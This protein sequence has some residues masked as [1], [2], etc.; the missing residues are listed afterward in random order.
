MSLV[1]K[2]GPSEQLFVNGAVLTNGERRSS[3]LVENA[4]Q[5]L[6]EKDILRE[7]EAS[8][9]VRAAYFAAQNVLLGT[10]AELGSITPFTEQIDCLRGAFIKPEH[11]ALLDEAERL[12]RAG[13]IYR[14]LVMLRDLVL[15]E[16]A[17][18]NM[19]PPDRFRRE[20]PSGST[21]KNPV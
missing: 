11:L 8:T 12:V 3:L 4:A 20:T 10:R 18:L 15:Y 1:L 19:Q 6:R 14:A 17:L 7:A 5:I 13:N 2:L 9:P 16:A 21:S